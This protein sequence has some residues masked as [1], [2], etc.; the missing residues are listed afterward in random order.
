M[1][2]EAGHETE[3]LPRQ[4]GYLVRF[5]APACLHASS[6]ETALTRLLR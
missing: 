2:A 5:V 1:V 4:A 3:K 6:F